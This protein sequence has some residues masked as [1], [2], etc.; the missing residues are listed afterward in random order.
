MKQPLPQTETDD[1]LWTPMSLSKAKCWGRGQGG[2]P[3][4]PQAGTCYPRGTHVTGVLIHSP[5]LIRSS[6]HADGTGHCLA[7]I[8]TPMFEEYFLGSEGLPSTW[9][10]SL[11]EPER[12]TGQGVWNPV[13]R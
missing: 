5:C 2:L 3:W 4:G 6:R 13:L 7:M 9:S 8:I 10:D 11:D 1:L 12:N